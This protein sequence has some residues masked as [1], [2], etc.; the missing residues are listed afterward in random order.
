[1][2]LP[3]KWINESF[4]KNYSANELSD[5]LTLSGIESEIEKQNGEDI[6]DIQLTPNR[7]DCFSRFPD[8]SIQIAR[9]RLIHSFDIFTSQLKPRRIHIQVS[10]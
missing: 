6:L 4:K 8:A 2:K 3:V 5:L 10:V 9:D 7:A 1:M